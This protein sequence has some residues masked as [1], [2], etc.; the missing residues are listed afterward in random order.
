MVQLSGSGINSGH[1]SKNF[2]QIDQRG[3]FISIVKL[4]GKVFCK[5]LK[6]RANFMKEGFYLELDFRSF[7]AP[8]Y[9][10]S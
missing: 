4:L 7:N 9:S 1:I 2:P 5:I 6:S 3:Q 10:S 8:K